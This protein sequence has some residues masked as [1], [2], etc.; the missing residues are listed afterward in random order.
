[1]LNLIGSELRKKEQTDE[2]SPYLAN[3]VRQVH[4]LWLG[5]LVKLIHSSGHLRDLPLPLCG[6]FSLLQ[7]FPQSTL[8][9]LGH[10][11]GLSSPFCEV[12]PFSKN[13]RVGFKGTPSPKADAYNASFL[14]SLGAQTAQGT[15]L[16]LIPFMIRT[17]N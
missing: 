9:S 16:F 5:R 7:L 10:P 8:F 4:S 17:G 2:W 12:C 14:Q 1:M 15:Q 6:W 13:F 11:R 3:N